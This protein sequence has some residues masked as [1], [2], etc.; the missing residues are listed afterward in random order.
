MTVSSQPSIA[1]VAAVARNGVIGRHN[2]LPWH[3]PEDLQRFKALTMGHPVIMGRKTFDS[4]VAMLKKPLPGRTSIVISR[5]PGQL[6]LAPEWTDVRTVATLEEAL[7][8]APAGSTMH[9]IGGAQIYEL[10]MPHAT[11][12]YMTEVLSDFEGDAHF[13]HWDRSQWL[14]VSREHGQATA[15]GPQ[16]DFVEY[17]RR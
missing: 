16:Y 7:C 10:A 1:L 6:Q 14:E 12:L 9:V 17:R 8:Q 5:S 4:I 2:T 11:H 3:L 15:A 13:P